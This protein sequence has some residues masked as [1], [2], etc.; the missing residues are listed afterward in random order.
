MYQDMMEWMIRIL[1]GEMTGADE[2]L[3]LKSWANVA[4][5]WSQAQTTNPT[6]H[7]PHGPDDP[8]KTINYHC[9]DVSG[10]DGMDDQDIGWRN[11]WC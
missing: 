1:D 5:S 9:L 11:G 8:F 10:H 2:D 6:Q 7:D 3:W 4:E